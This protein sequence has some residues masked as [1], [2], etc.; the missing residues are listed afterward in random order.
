MGQISKDVATGH[1]L[2]FPAE[3]E[4]IRPFLSGFNINWARRRSAYNTDLSLYF[5]GPDAEFKDA[6]GFEFEILLVV[7]NYPTMEPRAIQAIEQ[8]FNEDPVKGRV[9]PT[10]FFIVSRAANATEWLENYVSI[11]PQSRLP[12]LFEA[13]FL[14]SAQG[15]AWAIRNR[16]HEKLFSRDLFDYQLPLD[17][18]LFFFGR[19]AIIAEYLDAIKK[20]QNRGLFGLRKTGKTSLLYKLRRLA[21]RD[22]HTV[23]L[24]Y[25]CKLPSI[26]SLS[27][28]QFI[29][30]LTRDISERFAVRLPKEEMHTSDRFLH[31]VRNTRRNSSVTLIFDEI[32][33]VSHKS[34][35]DPHWRKDFIP[36]WQTLWSAQSEVR[37]LS[38][39]VAGVNPSVVEEDTVEGVQNPVFGIVRPQYLTGLERSD[40]NSMLLLLGGRMG[41]RF[42]QGAV[43]YLLAR[44]GGHPLLTRMAC[45]YENSVLALSNVKRPAAI[46]EQMLAAHEA[47]RDTELTFYCRHIVSELKQFY[48]QEYEML[49][50]LAT[51][52]LADFLELSRDVE[53][54]GHI[55]GYGLVHFPQ[56][57][58]PS[59]AMPVVG[60]YLSSEIRRNLPRGRFPN[61]SSPD[62][63]QSF[64]R[65][66]AE[67]ILREFR[68]LERL[69][70]N[71]GRP[72]L[73]GANSVP[74]AERLSTIDASVDRH[75]F[76]NF[77]NVC[78]RC[79]V[80]P[81]IKRLEALR[82]ECPDLLDALE[83][84]RVYRHFHM[85]KELH[86]G[87]RQSF[88]SY[89]NRDIGGEQYLG[90]GDAY[91][92]LQHAV[93]DGLLFGAISEQARYEVAKPS[94]EAA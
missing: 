67:R 94:V 46:N 64:V 56:V 59:F 53:L 43:D 91:Y 79:V 84:V 40:V 2:T 15:D 58:R 88:D 51:E 37:R 14:R 23:V 78:Y 35:T 36:F 25:D 70:R 73:Y 50:L 57:G 66:R 27:W 63:R 16:L 21:G 9:D 33:Y 77:I 90:E 87:A 83:R 92:A 69:L 93:L 89:C 61:L 74:E 62:S 54:V 49:Q 4:L 18:D 52:Q 72:A 5:L 42:T 39:V 38:F 19:D 86:S 31:V 41:C 68:A 13:E 76:E 6:F 34:Q 29:D 20:S 28:E 44:Y 30:R 7:S 71:V 12:V 48:P 11:N 65:L 1:L 60:R 10:T 24:Y 8:F 80:E 55:R 32:E 3:L 45:S 26:R 81:V 82:V 17:S 85:H 47:E 22:K 75:T